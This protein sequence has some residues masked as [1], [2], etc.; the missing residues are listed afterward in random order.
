MKN[1]RSALQK[2][3]LMALADMFL[4]FGDKMLESLDSLVRILGSLLFLRCGESS[5]IVP[6][7]LPSHD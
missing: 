7:F 5:L 6:S 1:P 4:A 2:T 3:G